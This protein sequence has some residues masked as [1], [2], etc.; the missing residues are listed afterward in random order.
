MKIWRTWI[1]PKEEITEEQKNSTGLTT[2]KPPRS[3][4]AQLLVSI[5]LNV[6]NS[7]H[8]SGL[9]YEREILHVVVS[10]TILRDLLHFGQLFK[11]CGDIYFAQINHIIRQF[12]QRFFVFQV[13]SFLGNFYKNLATFY[14]SHWLWSKSYTDQW[15]IFNFNLHEK[16]SN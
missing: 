15:A 7:C 13:E 12:S 16:E 9:R 6:A 10:V 5:F 1:K 4:K 8:N 3:P 11:A 2:A 14:W